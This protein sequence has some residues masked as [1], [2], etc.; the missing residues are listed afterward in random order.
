LFNDLKELSGKN[1]ILDL[2]DNDK[3]KG[4]TSIDYE[5]PNQVADLM[6]NHLSKIF[7]VTY[8]RKISKTIDNL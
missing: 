7:L 8:R 5:D 4:V 3:L 6:A 1:D 2:S